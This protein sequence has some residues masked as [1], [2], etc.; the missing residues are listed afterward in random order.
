MLR[1][2]VATMLAGI[3]LVLLAINQWP[4]R[5]DPA[6]LCMDA[7]TR[8]LVRGI[9]LDGLTAGLKQHTEQMF[10]VWL[11]D[12]TDQ[13]RRAAT[14]MRGGVSAFTRAR[15]YVQRWDP[16]ACKGDRQ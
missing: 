4:A 12:D 3:A 15:A 13:P 6:P 14:G 1:V 11:K 5:S 10:D 9:M 7:A 16:Q 2:T 8:D